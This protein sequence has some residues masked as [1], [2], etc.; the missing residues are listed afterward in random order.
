MSGS[1]RFGMWYNIHKILLEQLFELLVIAVT[2]GLAPSAHMLININKYTT[3]GYVT[4]KFR[5]H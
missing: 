5:N 2:V 3:W 4:S 1:T